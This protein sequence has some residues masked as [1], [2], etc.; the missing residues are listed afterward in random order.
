VAIVEPGV[1][2]TPMTMRDRPKPPL[3]PYSNRIE[4]LTTFFLA[5][6]ENQTSPFVV[7]ETIRDIVE[8]KSARV[9]NP[10]GPDAEPFLNVRRTMSDEEWVDMGAASNSDWA[11]A[12]NKALGLNMKL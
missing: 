2:A 5:S 7:A 10:S 11:A 1:I 3:N 12:L 6:L 9:R 4:R 8:G